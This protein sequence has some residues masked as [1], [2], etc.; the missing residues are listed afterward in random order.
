VPASLILYVRGPDV[1]CVMSRHS[2]VKF[3]S[4]Y[5]EV[6]PKISGLTLCHSAVLGLDIYLFICLYLEVFGSKWEVSSRGLLGC[7]A[8]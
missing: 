2:K 6:K 8:I 5:L 4:T 1:I 7:D 3:R